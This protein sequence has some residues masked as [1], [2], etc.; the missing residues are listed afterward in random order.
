VIRILVVDDHPVVRDGVASPLDAA[1]DLEV[2]GQAASGP[3]AV[4]RTRQAEPDVV[5][6]DLRMPGGGGVDAVAEIRRL[7]RPAA[8]LMLT[9]FDTDSEIVAALEAGAIGYLLK[10][11]STQALQDAV[12]AAAA[13]ET[14]LSP[15]VAG[16]ITARMRGAEDRPAL[17][18][19]ETQVLELVA[20]GT[21]N[22]QIAKEL[23]VSEATV[24]THLARLYDKLGV[25]DR[26]AAVATAYRAG[27]LH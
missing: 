8:V 23:F 18:E 24:K 16:R 7:E 25:A 11:A 10:D 26:A 6:M 3:E 2:V 17:S 22:R 13:G 21:S 27:I 5:V 4:A 12:R 20:E 19:R 15:A 9:T 14:V 1:D